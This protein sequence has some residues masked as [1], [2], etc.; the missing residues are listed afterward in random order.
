MPLASLISVSRVR[1]LFMGNFFPFPDQ[2]AK[3]PK[4][5]EAARISLIFLGWFIFLNVKPHC[6]Q[7]SYENF[8]RFRY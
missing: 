1:G 5:S 7:W 8:I 6:F 2:E 4:Q 3:T